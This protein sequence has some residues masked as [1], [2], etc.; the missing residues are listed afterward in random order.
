MILVD[1]KEPTNRD[2]STSV[3]LHDVFAISPMQT[4]WNW[5][6]NLKEN[7][8]GTTV[9]TMNSITSP[10]VPPSSTLAQN[11]CLPWLSIA[12]LSNYTR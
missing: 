12:Y 5:S 7:V 9:S 1:G 2:N 8:A 4:N 6:L 3:N 11:S 10:G